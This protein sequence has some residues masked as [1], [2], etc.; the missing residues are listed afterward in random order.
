MLAS[1]ASQPPLRAQAR[2][3]FR[4]LLVHEYHRKS[5]R[6]NV[7]HFQAQAKERNA[8]KPAPGDEDLLRSSKIG[9]QLHQPTTTLPEKQRGDHPMLS[10]R[11]ESM[12]TLKTQN[13]CV[14]RNWAAHSAKQS[15]FVDTLQLPATDSC[16]RLSTH[17][18]VDTPAIDPANSAPA[19]ANALAN[20]PVNVPANTCTNASSI[21]SKLR[22]GHDVLLKVKFYDLGNDIQ[23]QE[24]GLQNVLVVHS[25]QTLLDLCNSFQC[26]GSHRL[27]VQKKLVEEHGLS[28]KI[29][30]DSCM[31]Y[32]DDHFYVNGP[33]DLSEPIRKWLAE[34]N[35][36]NAHVQGWQ[37][38][39]LS[40][41]APVSRMENV[42]ISS[43]NLILGEQYLYTHIG[44]CDHAVVF[45][46]CSLATK[47]DEADL[48]CYPKL[49]WK[50]KLPT[51]RCATCGAGA[52]VEVVGDSLSD[53]FPCYMCE[54]CDSMFHSGIDPNCGRRVLRLVTGLEHS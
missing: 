12:S 1:D 40:E 41:M 2:D 51:I 23:Y 8:W 35:T 26:A 46:E 39:E 9:I 52:Q 32:V 3:F 16:V 5:K 33:V 4:P 29:P 28:L 27:R 30:S 47:D 24:K 44:E 15:T 18:S 10:C 6:F 38:S 42:K 22:P 21:H 14:M 19:H 7:A 48:S 43:L 25:E 49:V 13:V 11:E 17:I 34:N 45:E 50:S 20:V 36:S 53:R 54:A 37:D 31:M